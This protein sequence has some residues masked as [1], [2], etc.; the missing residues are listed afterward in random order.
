MI[1][2]II[3]LCFG[4]LLMACGSRNSQSNNLLSIDGEGCANID[5]VIPPQK[6]NV[7]ADLIEEVKFIPIETDTI[8]HIGYIDKIAVYNSDY[9][10]LDQKKSRKLWRIDKEGK[11]LNTIGRLG[12]GAGEYLEPTDFIVNSSGVILLD[13][14]SRSLLFYDYDGN[15]K[16]KI[17]LQH[18]IYEITGM[19]DESLIFAIAGDN[20]QDK[21]AVD[22]E[23]LII[24]TKGELISHGIKNKDKLNYSAGYQSFLFGDKVVYFRP[25]HNTVYSIDPKSIQRRYMIN[26]QVYPLPQDY[27]KVCS[28]D[29]EK[30]IDK[31]ERRYG[32]FSGKLIE[33]NDHV[34]I[35][36]DHLDYPH[37]WTVYNKNTG[38]T[39]SG[40]IQISSS[41]GRLTAEKMITMGLYKHL[42]YSGDE[43]IGFLNAEYLAELDFADDYPVLRNVNVYSNPVIF[44]VRL[45]P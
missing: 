35:L 31:Y 12:R 18:I 30:F 40:P 34:L 37:I 11:F 6:I 41:D 2:R 15:F 26:T 39:T 33:T 20:R 32:Y 29:Y 16:N 36:S 9:Y 10:V 42:S 1:M 5:V 45:K 17:E 25:M 43:I 19:Q 21:D 14:Y 44:H 28:G 22:S 8:N 13:H 24:N 4:L 27:E 23:F 38:E 7:F 3:L